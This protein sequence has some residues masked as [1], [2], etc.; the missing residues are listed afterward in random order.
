MLKHSAQKPDLNSNSRI[1]LINSLVWARHCSKIASRL[2]K[3]AT[4]SSPSGIRWPAANNNTSIVQL[5][6]LCTAYHTK[7]FFYILQS[8]TL[9][10]IF[11]L[12]GCKLSAKICYFLSVWAESIYG[13]T[14]YLQFGKCRYQKIAEN[15]V[16]FCPCLSDQMLL[17]TVN[18]K[19]Y[20]LFCLFTCA[21]T[22]IG[23]T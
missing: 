5:W 4:S 8:F 18:A 11:C 22:W 2:S 21:S 7:H 12:H 10:V 19:F 13:H 20:C 6:S 17:N 3:P 15:V 23:L 16:I 1:S 9:S 14:C